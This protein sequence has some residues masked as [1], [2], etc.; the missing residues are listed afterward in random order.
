MEIRKKIR[1]NGGRK[2]G[3]I[4]RTN[5]ET[6]QFSRLSKCNRKYLY[7]LYKIYYYCLNIIFTLT[8]TISCKFK[9]SAIW[10]FSMISPN[11]AANKNLFSFIRS[12]HDYRL[13]TAKFFHAVWFA[14][15]YWTA[16]SM[17]FNIFKC[18]GCYTYHLV[19]TARLNFDHTAYL[20]N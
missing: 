18:I 19:K 12:T 5:E 16:E 6:A 8:V 4:K 7:L 2:I 17:H 20:R 14:P 15:I 13:L 3:R 11:S 10:L 9:I 1:E